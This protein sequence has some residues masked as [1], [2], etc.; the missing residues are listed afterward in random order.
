VE[1][2]RRRDDVRGGQ[3]DVEAGDLAVGVEAH[4]RGAAAVVEV[5]VRLTLG[6]E[7]AVEDCAEYLQF[8]PFE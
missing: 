2:R 7:E 6:G 8:D 1:L 3:S 5:V 4:L